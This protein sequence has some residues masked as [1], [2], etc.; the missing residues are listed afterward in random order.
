[1]AYINVSIFFKNYPK[2]NYV[3]KWQ[4]VVGL[5]TSCEKMDNNCKCYTVYSSQSMEMYTL[6]IYFIHGKCID[7]KL[8]H[9]L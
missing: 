3:D 7:I 8:S 6:T 2:K 4:L 1:M 9:H 5:F